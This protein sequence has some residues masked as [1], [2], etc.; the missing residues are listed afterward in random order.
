MGTTNPEKKMIQKII[1]M[2]E[3][4]LHSIFLELCNAYDA[5]DRELYLD[6]L[7]GYG[8][9]LMTICILQTY[10]SRLQMI[11]KVGGGHYGLAFHSHCGVTQAD[12]SWHSA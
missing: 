4:V 10:W 11:T 1:S 2:K 9:G 3:T 5:L 6:I 7:V 12:P 8:V